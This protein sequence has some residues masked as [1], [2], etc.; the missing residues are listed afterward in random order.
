MRPDW[1]QILTLYDHLLSLTP[2]PVV[3]MNRA[4]AMGEVRGPQTALDILDGLDLE[5]YHLYHATRADLLRRLGRHDDASDAYGRAASLAPTD[6]ERVF[7]EDRLQA[8][9]TAG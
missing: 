2:T 6:A 1:V 3:A 7:L 4:I 9:Q 5:E 8:T